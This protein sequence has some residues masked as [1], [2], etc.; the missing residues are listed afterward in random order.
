M[1]LKY[2][3]EISSFDKPNPG[4][5]SY[6]PKVRLRWNIYLYQDG[7]DREGDWETV[8]QYLGRMKGSWKFVSGSNPDDGQL[9]FSAEDIDSDPRY[10]NYRSYRYM[11]LYGWTYYFGDPW[12]SPYPLGGDGDITARGAD[13][14]WEGPIK[15]KIVATKK[16]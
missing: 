11:T 16:D 1:R 5:P 2:V 15:W 7:D 8:D 4:N 13:R 14:A 9:N 6:K 12:A 10:R 3:V